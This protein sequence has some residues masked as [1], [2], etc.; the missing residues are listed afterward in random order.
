MQKMLERGRFGDWSLPT[1]IVEGQA[2]FQTEV[3]LRYPSP[4]PRAKYPSQSASDTYEASEMFTFMTSVEDLVDPARDN[5]C[6][7]RISWSR[8]S[9]FL[10]WMHMGNRPGQLICHCHGSRLQGGWEAVPSTMRTWVEANA[11]KYACAPQSHDFETTRNATSWTEARKQI[12]ARRSAIVAAPVP[13]GIN[14][15][16]DM[17]IIAGH[18]GSWE[19][20]YTHLSA[21]F[22]VSDF[23]RCRLDIAPRGAV[24]AQRNTYTWL[25]GR[26][27]SL[28]FPCALVPGALIIDSPKLWGV[29]LE[30]RSTLGDGDDGDDGDGG[31]AGDSNAKGP[32]VVLFH[33]KLKPGVAGDGG[34]TW[35][36]IRK[37]PGDGDHRAR[38]WQSISAA[39]DL[40]RL[41]LVDERRMTAS[42]S[43]P[44][45]ME[46]DA[47]AVRA[48]VMARSITPS[49]PTVPHSADGDIGTMAGLRRLVGTWKGTETVLA[50]DGAVLRRASITSRCG[51]SG[52]RWSQQVTIK[53]S[54]AAGAAGAGAGAGAGTGAGATAELEARE[55]V[56]QGVVR[57][58]G[59]LRITGTNNAS[60]EVVAEAVVEELLSG[61]NEDLAPDV[62]V[63]YG[64]GR[65]ACAG[66]TWWELLRLGSDRVLHR[67]RQVMDDTGLLHYVVATQDRSSAENCFIK[68]Q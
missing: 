59:R 50:P 68:A 38:V 54:G 44:V 15:Q 34:T 5:S 57:G 17:P 52:R 41:V 20:T 33:G 47:D 27:V 36:L 22:T 14:M 58:D 40:S 29:G 61:F 56:W 23:H 21:A 63:L 46:V 35:E 7:V 62:L 60:G 53:A 55:E 9:H 25:D 64:E 32:H 31:D 42:P 67:T 37:L 49:W 28:S 6:R 19:G 10:P 8:V 12:D 2:T 11:P 13:A 45:G 66:Q 3:H 24:Q 16:D 4:L 51:W 1:T 18:A 48:T 43:W 39:G 65:G 26:R 30:R